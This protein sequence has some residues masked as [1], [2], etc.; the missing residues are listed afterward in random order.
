M[1][2]RESG[3]P[4][5][6]VWESF[7]DAAAIVN[8]LSGGRVD[9]DVVEFGSGY[10]TFTIP[11]AK[12]AS[13]TVV[14]L[15][16]DPLMVEAT[17]ARATRA[18]VTNVVVEQ[19]DFVADGSGRAAGSASFAMLF[20]ILHIEDPVGLL[21]EAHRMLRP[22]GRAGVIHWKGSSRFPCNNIR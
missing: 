15:D 21:R 20:N 8:T 12:R 10:G 11:V 3:M 2:A 5:A 4:P 1:Q 22:G 7:F 13:G 6:D 18:G 17:A 9:G 16:I 14:A 19:R